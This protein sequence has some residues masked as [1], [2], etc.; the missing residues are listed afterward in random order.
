MR[1]KG[2]L[3]ISY[4]KKGKVEEF[5]MQAPLDADEATVLLHVLSRCDRS[6]QPSVDTDWHATG[7]DRIRPQLEA[8]GISEVEWEYL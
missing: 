3:R 6:K 4:K 7:T 1:E 5:E 8:L 2:T